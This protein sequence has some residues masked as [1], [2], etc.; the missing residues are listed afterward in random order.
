MR[1]GDTYSTARLEAAC[2]RA[3]WI[4]G[5]SY[6][7]VKSILQSGLDQLPL[8]QQ[9][10]LALPQHHEHIRSGLYYAAAATGEIEC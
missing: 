2:D 3:L 10:P 5:I 6:R 8:E 4:K 9:I 7:S 1:L